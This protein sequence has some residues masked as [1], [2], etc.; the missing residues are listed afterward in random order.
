MPY[1]IISIDDE[2][3]VKI[4]ECRVPMDKEKYIDSLKQTSQYGEARVWTEVIIRELETAKEHIGFFLKF[5]D[6]YARSIGDE[7]RPF[8]IETWEKGYEKWTREWEL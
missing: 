3:S 1:T 2:G 6:D 4:D 7:R 5:I 8:S